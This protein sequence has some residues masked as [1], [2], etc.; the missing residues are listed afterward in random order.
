MKQ[1]DKDTLNF[2]RDTLA[3]LNEKIE[4]PDTLR[5][6]SIVAL[7]ADK[8]QNKKRPGKRILRALSTAAAALIIA[9][10][11]GVYLDSATKTEMPEIYAQAEYPVSGNKEEDIVEYFKA[12]YDKLYRGY[13]FNAVADSVADGGFLKGGTASNDSASEIT[14][15]SADNADFGT[16]N[17]QIASIDEED[18]VKNDGKYLYI[19][20]RNSVKIVDAANMKLMSTI[21]LDLGNINVYDN[22]IY[23]YKNRLAVIASR[24]YE[25]EKTYIRLY[26]ISDRAKPELIEEFNQQG[27]F[28]SS[29]LVGSRIV[30]LSQYYFNSDCKKSEI[31]YDKVAPHVEI[32]GAKAVIGAQM[33]T[34]IPPEDENYS[35]SNIVMTT[36]DLDET[37]PEFISSAVLGSGSDI[38]CTNE[39]LYIISHRNRYEEIDGRIENFRSVTQINRFSIKDGVIEHKASGEVSGHTLNQFSLDERKGYLRIATTDNFSST[40]QRNIITVLDMNLKEVAKIGGIAPGETIQ[41]VR[42]IGDY[43]YVVTFLQTDPLFVID[44]KDMKNPKIVGELKIPGFSSYLHPFNGYLVGI[45]TDGDDNGAV[46]ALKISLFDISDPTKPQEIDRF[47]L[48][49]AWANSFHKSVMDCSSK[50][51]LGFIYSDYSTDC[52]NFCTLQIKDGKIKL[53]GSYSNADSSDSESGM[54][55]SASGSQKLTYYNTDAD[56]ANIQ[57]GTYIGD[58]LYTISLSRICSYPLFGGE[59]TAKLDY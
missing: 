4:T 51:I 48:K 52:Q 24:E 10:G 14:Q 9:V 32:N 19:L 35:S 56:K 21:P 17:T 30:L 47:I 20:T 13:G 25:E 22:G 49:N 6:N 27:C 57:R 5:E 53:I 7:V 33:I 18:I 38:Y 28:F 41:S 39:N 50:D 34:V 46:D 55:Y 40:E 43:G 8:Q 3:P 45:G 59:C 42:Y 15:E 23:I 37:D 29:R 12:A 26:D 36:V 11:L 44:F 31:T 1:K 58:T 16:T 2:I 54:S